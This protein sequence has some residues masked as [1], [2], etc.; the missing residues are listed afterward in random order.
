MRGAII[1]GTGIYK[2]AGKALEPQVMDT[3]WGP[4]QLFIGQD[5]AEDMVFLP[6]HGPDHTIPPHRINFR[7]NLKA[8][9]QLGV[10]RI[11]ATFAVGSLQL[12]VPPRALVALD[13]FI[14]FT[15]GREGTFFDGGPA[16]L[17]HTE[18]T[19]P[20][21]AGLRA[22]LLALA[23]E[24]GL[25][26][27]PKGTYVCANGPRFETAAEVRMMGQLGGDVVG[28]TGVPE[29][30]LARELGLHYAAVA[31]SIN[32]GAGLKGPL[33][34]VESGLDEL[35]TALLSVFMDVLRTPELSSC[36]CEAAVH[37]MHPPEEAPS[38]S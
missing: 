7:A 26:I 1:G 34:I 21:C 15:S 4:A 5:E 29:V 28:M 14:D 17:A 22:A 19:E 38:R 32:W 11:M 12:T 23:A 30:S 8:L 10:K 16:G 9:E 24:R 6:R 3:P 13:Q 18:M 37:M 2:I 20:Y 35:R 27:Q 25:E 31:L 36:D 33:T